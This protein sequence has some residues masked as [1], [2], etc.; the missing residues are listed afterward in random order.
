MSGL[1]MNKYELSQQ[2]FELCDDMNSEFRSVITL[3]NG[4][5]TEEKEYIQL[6]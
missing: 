6:L 5:C 1:S 4:W 3:L 2:L